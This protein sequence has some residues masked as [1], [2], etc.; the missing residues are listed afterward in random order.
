MEEVNLR[1]IHTSWSSRDCEINWSKNSNSGFSWDFVSLEF[2]FKFEDWSIGKDQSNLVL[3]KRCKSSEFRD[4][5][6]EAL[7][8]VFELVLFDTF[9]SHLDDLLDES[10]LTDD[11]VGT[12][13]SESLTDLVDLT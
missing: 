10:V 13:C 12:V 4:F 2:G 11:K 7:L 3:E 6:T 1:W 5:S 9:G 8:E